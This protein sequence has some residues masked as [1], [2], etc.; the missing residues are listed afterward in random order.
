MKIGDIKK[1]LQEHFTDGLVTIAGSG[2]SMEAGLPGMEELGKH[3]VEVMQKRCEGELTKQ[4]EPVEA[5]LKEGIALEEALKDSEIDDPLREEIIDVTAEF[6]KDRESEVLRSV[7]LGQ[8]TL[9]FGD[10]LPYLSFNTERVT[11]ITTNYDRL[12][13]VASEITGFGID[14]LFPGQYYGEFN[15]DLSREALW[16][17][18]HAQKAKS[19]KRV[20]RKHVA[21]LKPH[22]S[23][24]WF[25][26]SGR[27]IRCTLPIDAPRL[28]ITPGQS[29]YRMGYE[30]P[31]DQHRDA[32]NRAIDRAAR[33]LVI[34]Y[35]FNDDQLETHLKPEIKKGKPCVILTKQLTDNGEQLVK[36]CKSILSIS[37]ADS[38]GKVAT[39]VVCEGHEVILG[40]KRIWRLGEFIEEILK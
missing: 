5:E 27:P 23:L 4:W 15:P 16:T 28:M 3:L 22:G 25:S 36:E 17:G 9:V 1:R 26:Q 34:G 20:F 2:L 32:A 10:L 31:F 19:I 35:G 13:E 24:D 30:K 29:K 11:V 37:S 8:K 12:I 40:D 7:Y 6:M 39:K 14:T 33:F 38:N 21:V 18:K